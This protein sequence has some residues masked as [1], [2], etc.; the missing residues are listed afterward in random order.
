[1]SARVAGERV[2]LPIVLQP[3][4]AFADTLSQS[5]VAFVE[6]ED[7]YDLKIIHSCQEEVVDRFLGEMV[8]SRLLIIM[9][10]LPLVVSIRARYTRSCS[11]G[12]IAANLEV[13]S[14]R[15]S[16]HAEALECCANLC[17]CRWLWL[18]LWLSCCLWCGRT[19][20]L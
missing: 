9:G 2:V 1:M 6:I 16:V 10:E 7:F 20:R 19:G 5:P 13:L 18:W 17:V 4:S 15:R 3:A 11:R 8:V 12:L 14:V